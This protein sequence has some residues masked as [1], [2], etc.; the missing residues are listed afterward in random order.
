MRLGDG[1]PLALSPDKRWVISTPV[2][3]NQLVVLPT[4]VGQSRPLPNGPIA[5]YFPAARFLP[6]G[7]RFL[8]A[9]AERNVR[10]ASTCSRSTAATRTPITPEGVFG[11]LA[12]LPDG[13]H[14]VTRGLDRRL[15]LFSL[16]GGA[17]RPIAGAE[18]RDLPIVVSPDGEWLYV[19]GPADLPGEIARVHLRSG[20]REPVQTVLPPDPA[21][22]M[23][24]LRI[25]MAPDG[26][27]YVYTFIRALSALY[28]V[29][30]LR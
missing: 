29:D 11:R 5:S 24:I 10:T 19:Q 6:D 12:V 22:I 18:G 21:G 20:R 17:P 2:A 25:A 13:Q 3:A 1:V 7:R 9:A 23:D 27:A 8:V 16:D 28:L 14:F 30:G 4:G 15:A 26:R